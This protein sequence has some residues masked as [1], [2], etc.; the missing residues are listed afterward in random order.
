MDI[1]QETI[2]SNVRYTKYPSALDEV[3]NT[4]QNKSEISWIWALS[5]ILWKMH[6]A[7]VGSIFHRQSFKTIIRTYFC[8]INRTIVPQ[9]INT[10]ALRLSVIETLKIGE[11]LQSERRC[12]A[13]YQTT[14]HLKR[15]KC[16]QYINKGH[17][18][19]STPFDGMY[20]SSTTTLFFYE[21]LI[22]QRY[23]LQ[24]NDSG[25]IRETHRSRNFFDIS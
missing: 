17:L 12:P 5:L 6:W 10:Q 16:Q 7:R 22:F 11:F 24:G 9:I 4:K 20:T 23:Y 13:S 1:P 19:V 21:T 3:I 15:G 18:M 2:V 8:W 14:N 25:E